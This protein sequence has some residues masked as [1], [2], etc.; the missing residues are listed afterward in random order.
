MIAPLARAEA[1]TSASRAL[2]GTLEFTIAVV[3]K[4]PATPAAILLLGGR[5]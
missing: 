3:F 5:R 2:E 4:M 1:A